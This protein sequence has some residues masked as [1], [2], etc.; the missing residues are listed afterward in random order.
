[1]VGDTCPAESECAFSHM[2]PA[3][4]MKSAFGNIL[5]LSG[6]HEIAERVQRDEI[7]KPDSGYMSNESINQVFIPPPALPVTS[8]GAEYRKLY[9]RLKVGNSRCSDRRGY[10]FKEPDI[11]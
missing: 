10:Q 6:Q 3:P 5:S 8:Y 4:S 1:M 7:S 9:S 11:C 2:L